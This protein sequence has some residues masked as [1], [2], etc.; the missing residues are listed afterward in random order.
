MGVRLR[1][2][3]GVTHTDDEDWLYRRG[4]Y[5]GDG[6]DVP[7]APAAAQPAPPTP[8]AP[9]GA[10][11]GAEPPR[12]AAPTPVGHY[13]TDGRPAGGSS[14]RASVPPPL[15]PPAPPVDGGARPPA[16]R[17][18]RRPARILLGAVMLFVAYVIAVPL[19]TWPFVARVDATPSGNRPADTPGHVFVLAGSDSREGMSDADRERLG[20]GEAAGRRTDTIMLLYVP[21]SGRAALISV[22]RDSYV[23]IPGHAKNKI[24]AAYAFGGPPLLVQTVEQSTGLRVDGF[25]EIGFGGFEGVVDAVGGIEMCPDKAIKDPASNLDIPAGC[26]RMDG[27][28]ALGYVRMRK[29][30]PEGD[31]GRAKRQREMVAGLAKRA[32]SPA[33]VLLPWRW[34]GLHSSL[35]RGIELGNEVGVG[36]MFALGSGALKMASGQGD[37]LVVPIG[38]PDYRTSAGSS[39]LWDAKKSQALFDAM[40]RGEG[41]LS[42]YA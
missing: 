31:F 36:E 16:G 11:S 32:L 9:T 7:P 38:N 29:A 10:P 13:G 26:Q 40:R 17:K 24:N 27:A 14:A 21:P 28:T 8:P 35:A 20:T 19:A 41:D 5:A 12:Y 42:S 37:M 18:R 2:V 1:T 4:R 15:A 22:P 6:Q 23:A 34:W 25:A 30:D 33:T 3:G 39:V